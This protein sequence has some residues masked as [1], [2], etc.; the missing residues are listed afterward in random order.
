[1]EMNRVVVTGTASGIGRTIAVRLAADGWAVDGIDRVPQEP[2]DNLRS[3]LGDVD[4]SA[5]LAEIARGQDGDPPLTAWV[6]NAAIARP[7]SILDASAEDVRQTITTNLLG[8]YWGCAAAIG[9]FVRG[10]RPGAIVNVSSI[11]GTRGFAGWAA[12]D[13]AKGGVDSLTRSIAVD[14]G[15]RGI[16]VN[17]VAPGVVA[18]PLMDAVEAEL[19]VTASVQTAFQPLG[20]VGRPEEIAAVVSFLVSTDSSFVTGQVIN[21]D[22]GAST[23]VAPPPPR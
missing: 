9:E 3:I 2:L 5:F 17:A 13:T 4:D 20:R 21:V 12:Y 18:T 7:G 19:G 10:S 14:Y 8:Y 6:N 1:M 23:W 11:H 16:R 15:P 22:G